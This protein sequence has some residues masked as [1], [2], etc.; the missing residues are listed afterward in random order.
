MPQL[1]NSM[2]PLS[3]H[4]TPINWCVIELPAR[5]GGVEPSPGDDDADEEEDLSMPASTSPS[6]APKR[7]RIDTKPRRQEE[8][9]RTTSQHQRSVP[10]HPKS[11]PSS[12]RQNR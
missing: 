1:I 8:T 5:R 11:T 9:L 6:P 3:A 4:Y 2:D 10:E 12:L 7:A